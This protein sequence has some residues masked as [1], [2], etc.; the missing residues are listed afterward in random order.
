MTVAVEYSTE[1]LYLL[2]E[3]FAEHSVRR[4]RARA[5]ERARRAARKE[6]ERLRHYTGPE[7]GSCRCCG[8]PVAYPVSGLCAECGAELL[9]GEIPNVVGS[10]RF[11]F[12]R[13]SSIE[14]PD[15]WQENAV[16]ALEGE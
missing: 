12:A 16:R 4:D 11:A 7:P 15:P 8:D 1:D 3:L 10:H 13:P 5:M 9:R 6:R 2:A 14:E